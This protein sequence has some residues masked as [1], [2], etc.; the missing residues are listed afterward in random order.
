[1]FTHTC[2]NRGVL[3]YIA[4]KRKNDFFLQKNFSFC[5]FLSKN[6]CLQ[7]F[8]PSILS[9]REKGVYTDVDRACAFARLKTL[10]HEYFVLLFTFGF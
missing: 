7:M 3:F 6:D 1:M 8:S 10:V 2:F 9:K 4:N 5:F